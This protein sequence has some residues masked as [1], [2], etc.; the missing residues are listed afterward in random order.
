[1]LEGVRARLAKAIHPG[2]IAHEEM[3]DKAARVGRPPIEPKP[4]G[5]V[6]G[7]TSRAP[8]L[9]RFLQTYRQRFSD[10]YLRAAARLPFVQGVL[11]TVIREALSSE[12]YIL[13]LK[14]E[15]SNE[16]KTRLLR[17]LAQPFP[18]E[19]WRSFIYKQLDNLL[20]IGR[21]DCE[22]LRAKGG[23]AARVLMGLSDLDEYAV[24]E[25]RKARTR[26][27]P[28]VRL[29]YYDP[30]TIKPNRGED[31]TFKSP[32]F[33]QVGK[34]GG[35]GGMSLKV[36][37]GMATWEQ[38]DFVE[39]LFAP[40][41]EAE[42]Y[43]RGVGPV[44]MAMPLIQLL[45]SYLYF[46]KDRIENPTIDKLISFY[47]TNDMQPLTGEQFGTLAET[48]REDVKMGRMP[49][50]EGVQAR[51]DDIGGRM[52]EAELLPLIKEF[53]LILYQII[54]AGLVELGRVEDVNRSTS[55]QQ[56]AAAQRQAIGTI[57]GILSEFVNIS[58]IGDDWSGF[59]NLVF[60]WQPVLH[61]VSWLQQARTL[62]DFVKLGMVPGELA[63]EY[64]W[65]QIS[66]MMKERGAVLP[67]EAV[68]TAK[69]FDVGDPMGFAG[70]LER[71][72]ELAEA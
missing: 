33:A 31:G 37:P 59:D 42:A 62:F 3:I 38:E 27:G 66:Q 45:W 5:R 14:P 2:A 58:I 22:K 47:V 21:F 24:E 63:I 36:T 57:K 65:P 4:A 39:M 26:R 28:I 19:T 12:Y 20:V 72:E 32:A 60:A 1:M 70:F 6:F 71:L 18:G 23:Q 52:R 44:E 50:L 48:M 16:P 30:A 15:E 53:E 68:G 7:I 46:S 29:A 25:V 55:E 11:Q 40:A 13:E 34:L 56:I 49:V 43:G 35:L 61:G 8:G 41:V 9:G 10:D 51:V 54:G 69:A 67:G 64:L 17:L